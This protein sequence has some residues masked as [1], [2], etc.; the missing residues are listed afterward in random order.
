MFIYYIAIE[1]LAP[2]TVLN[3]CEMFLGLGGDK[4]LVPEYKSTLFCK[5]VVYFK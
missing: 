5:H 3:I 1:N 4:E 2:K